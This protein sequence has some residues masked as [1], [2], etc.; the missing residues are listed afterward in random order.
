MR[1]IRKT[2]KKFPTS[3][4]LPCS[5]L[6]WRQLLQVPVQPERGVFQRRVRPVPGDDWWENMTPTPLQTC[7]DAAWFPFFWT[8]FCCCGGDGRRPLTWQTLTERQ[9]MGGHRAAQ[10]LRGTLT[11]EMH[12]GNQQ[13]RR[14]LRSLRG[15]RGSTPDPNS[16][17]KRES[18]FFEMIWRR[19]LRC[20][21]RNLQRMV[22][23]NHTDDSARDLCE[24]TSPKL[25]T[26]SASETGAKLYVCTSHCCHIYICVFVYI[27]VYHSR[28]RTQSSS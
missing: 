26:G 4:P 28:V 12:R 14:T 6:C 16:R 23:F 2:R 21:P 11:A 18:Y 5:H 10:T 8:F 3:L 25:T 19:F 20:L 22:I 7:L 17:E 13:P 1:R 24:L 9:I 15:Q 27:P